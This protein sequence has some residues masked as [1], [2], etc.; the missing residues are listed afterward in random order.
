MA[1]WNEQN[2]HRLFQ[3]SIILKSID[4]GI[5]LVGGFLIL[6]IPLQSVVDFVTNS[7]VDEL[8]ENPGNFIASSML[9]WSHSLSM[10]VKLFAAWYLLSHGIVKTILLIGLVKEY[11]WAF[12]ASLV[13]FSAFLMYQVYLLIFKTHSFLL[14][15]LTIFNVIFIWLIYHEYRI[16]KLVA[17]H[18][19]SG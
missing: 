19:N 5:Q 16:R 13:I 12:P 14:L 7:T 3:W 18:K 10:D 2:T 11:L 8:A 17:L 6:V 15:G 4:A 9:T 1:G